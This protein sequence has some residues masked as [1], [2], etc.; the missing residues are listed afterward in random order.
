MH[1]SNVLPSTTR[2]DAAAVTTLAA[3][4]VVIHSQVMSHLMCHNG[5]DKRHIVGIKL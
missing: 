5:G 3:N 1:Q 2:H 4:A